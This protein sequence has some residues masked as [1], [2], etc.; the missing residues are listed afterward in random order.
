M[1]ARLSPLQ[2]R[3]LDAMLE[4]IL[5]ADPDSAYWAARVAAH[6]VRSAAAFAAAA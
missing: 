1:D 5:T 3:T 6:T 4:T 2:I